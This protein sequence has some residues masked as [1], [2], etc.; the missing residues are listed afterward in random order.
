MGKFRIQVDEKRS[1]TVDKLPE[2]AVEDH[3]ECT[4]LLI[5]VG[6]P[7]FVAFFGTQGECPI[8][9]ALEQ[10]GFVRRAVVTNCA[11]AR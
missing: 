11:L 10:L 6:P 2:V 5:A 7:V 8:V 4:F 9:L 1:E 3:R